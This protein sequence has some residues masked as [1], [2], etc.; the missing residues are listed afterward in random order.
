MRRRAKKKGKSPYKK[1]GKAPYLYSDTL[2]SWQRAIKKGDDSAARY[3]A[4]EH[5]KKFMPTFEAR[6]AA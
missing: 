6:R 5:R 3:Y 4:E 2:R 1:H